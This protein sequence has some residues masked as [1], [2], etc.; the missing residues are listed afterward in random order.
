M[1]KYLRVSAADLSQQALGFT[2]P[3]TKKGTKIK[4]AMTKTYGS[5]KKAESVFYASINKG[6]IKG[7][8]KDSDE[9]EFCGSDPYSTGVGAPGRYPKRKRPHPGN[10]SEPA[11]VG[12]G[13]PA[14]T[15]DAW[16]E[17]AREAA[18]EARRR[19]AS[20]QARIE[21]AV[22]AGMHS[23]HTEQERN[24]RKDTPENRARWRAFT[25]RANKELGSMMSKSYGGKG[26]GLPGA[27]AYGPIEG[28]RAGNLRTGTHDGIKYEVVFTDERRDFVMHD[29]IEFDDASKLQYTDEG[30]LKAIPRICRTGIQLYGGDECGVPEKPLV[31]VYRPEDQVFKTATMHGYARL[32]ITLN[33]P[34]VMVSSDNWKDY[35][36]GETGDE[37]TRDGTTVRVP[38]MLRDAKAV[39]AFKQGVNQL[40]VGYVCDLKW[41]DGKTTAG[42]AYDAIQTN[43]RPNHLAVVPAA[44][45][46]PTLVIGDDEKGDSDMTV[47]MTVDGLQ[48]SVADEQSASI[49]QR[50]I[51]NLR[52]QLA[53]VTD[54]FKKKEDESDECEDA[55][56]K[57]EADAKKTLEAKD[58]EIA[59]L[60]KQAEDN[61]VTPAQLDAMVKDRLVVIDKARAAF[62]RVQ[63]DGRELSDIRK[64]VVV[65]QIAE[66]KDWSDEKVQG[67]FDVMTAQQARGATQ[68]N[69]GDVVQ[70]FQQPNYAMRDTRQ[71]AYDAYDKRDAEAWRNPGKAA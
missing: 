44:R 19:G 18:V 35:A 39:A 40:S 66:A 53:E 42:E 32:P 4:R 7:A 27:R 57:F 54:A 1:G 38:F 56:R 28:G 5:K 6:K 3:L 22:K 24:K 8:H 70:S 14:A 49:I 46:G 15:G 52:H 47:K 10:A 71:E 20:K 26:R 43:I 37:V 16:S 30:Y 23:F 9:T 58:G 25:Q 68:T 69:M 29:A 55:A 33:H 48:C 59:A 12:G 11:A 36:V 41:Q 63:F 60:K 64:Q 62:P 13:N 31:R 61:K 34:N 51:D 21:Q 45:G 17:E 50:T 67:A 65:N 2:M